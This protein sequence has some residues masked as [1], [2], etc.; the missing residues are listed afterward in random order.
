M[1]GMR[2]SLLA[3]LVAVTASAQTIYRWVDGQGTTH[4]TDN[5]ASIPKSAKVMTTDGEE[6]STVSG[7]SSVNQ[8]VEPAVRAQQVAAAKQTEAE[9]ERYWRDQFR[10][11]RDRVRTL[12]DEVSIDKKKVEDPT[13]MPMTGNWN[14]GY[15]VYG[16]YGGAGYPQQQGGGVYVNGQGRGTVGG[17]TLTVGAGAQV[18]NPSLPPVWGAPCWYVADPEYDRVRERLERNQAALKRARE[19]FSDLERRAANNSVPFEWRR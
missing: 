12:E 4:Y 16:L 10:T 6:I 9:Q 5:L 7:S 15:G 1:P 14:C 18:R 11:T 19:D 3:C 2:W 8:P 17:G 13:R